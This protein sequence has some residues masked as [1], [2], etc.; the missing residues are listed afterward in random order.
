MQIN[1]VI[2]LLTYLLAYLVTYLH[3]YLL[4]PTSG[5]AIVRMLHGY[6]RQRRTIS[7]FSATAGLLNF[8]WSRTWCRNNALS[9]HH[10]LQGIVR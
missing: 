9:L 5:I 4:I 3:T 7:S 8:C 6:S 2:Y 1:S 10:R